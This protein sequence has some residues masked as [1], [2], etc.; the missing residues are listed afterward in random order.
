VNED[1]SKDY[2]KINQQGGVFLNYDENS[3]SVKVEAGV[4]FAVQKA[5]CQ[6]QIIATSQAMPIFGQFMNAKGLKVLV[7]NLE[8]E[9]QEELRELANE[10][11]EELK[12]QQ[13]Q[14]MEMQKEA[15]QNNPAMM[16]AKND[17]MKMQLDAQQDQAENQIKAAQVAVSKQ[18]ADTNFM[19]VLADVNMAKAQM[20]VA[21]EKAHAEE[22]RA[23]VDLA[24]KH[25]D[26]KHTH[27]M[28]QKELEHTISES[29]RDS[30]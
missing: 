19:K 29:K 13:Q 9:G 8:V 15:S 28:N 27:V 3:L 14:Q 21:S 17:Q 1:G 30:T 22:T 26:M 6:Q 18:E 16:K 10:F 11:M 20:M 25:A 4:N 7:N 5:R 2:K 12:Q 24:I 23:A